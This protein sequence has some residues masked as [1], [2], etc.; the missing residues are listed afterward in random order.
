MFLSISSILQMESSH[1]HMDG[2][3]PYRHGIIHIA[4][5]PMHDNPAGKQQT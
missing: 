2:L 5:N 3:I 4:E 1:L